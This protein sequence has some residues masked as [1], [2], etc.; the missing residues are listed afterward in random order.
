[1]KQRAMAKGS[2]GVCDRPYTTI[3]KFSGECSWRQISRL[4]LL[5]FALV[6]VSSCS[7][8][9]V[10]EIKAVPPGSPPEPAAAITPHQAQPIVAQ[11]NTAMAEVLEVSVS[12]NPG[13]YRFSVTIR[14]PDTGC[15]QYADWWEVLTQ[16]GQLSYRRILLHSHVDEQPFTRSGGPAPIQPTD[17]VIVRAHMHPDGYG[18][19]AQ[20]GSVATGFTPITLSADF[21]ADLAAQSPQPSGC[22]F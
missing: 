16:A 8:R 2:L 15:D 3:P 19:L 6:N 7:S 21:A 22:N 14:S 10:P 12:G 4:L 5:A 1:M 9:Q 17:E 18:A 13:A 11:S 20:Q